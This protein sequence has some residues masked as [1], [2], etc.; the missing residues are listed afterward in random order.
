M[1]KLAYIFPGQGSQYVGMG[2]A[3]YDTFSTVRKTFEE[4]DEILGFPLT[5]VMFEGPNEELVKTKNT[6][7]AIL[8]HSIALLRVL[9]EEGVRPD[10][11]AGHSLGEYS[12]L[13][14]VDSLTY[15]D[16]LL[17]VRLR[18]ELMY[19]AG[20][21]QPGTMA[22]VLGLASEHVE[23]VCREASDAGIVEPANYN[24]AEQIVV[25]GEREGVDKAM[26]LAR[27]KGAKRAIPLDVSGA[28][29]S[30]LMREALPDLVKH[31]DGLD[32]SD[33][34]IPVVANVDATGVQGRE[35][36][37][38]RLKQQLMKPV[39]WSNSIRYIRDSGVQQCVEVGPGKVLCR[40]LKKVD[41][42]LAGVYLDGVEQLESFLSSQ[43]YRDEMDKL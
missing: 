29:H 23:E 38:E 25:S 13:V 20:V 41:D 27:E 33:A 21:K 24:S 10:I 37:R 3:C 22:A 42:S 31:L 9:E 2:K 17:T 15:H 14:C 11:V 19:D 32:I 35:E 40:L 30:S 7:P 43:R 18:G 36:I 6:Q 28:F 16:A 1:S 39:Q 4:A 12:A 26:Q 8:V 5:R 34:R